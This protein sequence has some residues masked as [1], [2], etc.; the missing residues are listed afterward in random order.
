MLSWL[1]PRFFH[2]LP[3]ALCFQFQS[4]TLMATNAPP[5]QDHRH[6]IFD[7]LLHYIS[8]AYYILAFKLLTQLDFRATRVFRTEKEG[9]WPGQFPYI[10]PPI[11]LVL[12]QLLPFRQFRLFPCLGFHFLEVG[13][14]PADPETKCV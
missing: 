6:F 12:F 13:S 1:P 7:I 2:P 8:L 14:L 5:G 10:R 3:K 9:E 4:E 11:Q